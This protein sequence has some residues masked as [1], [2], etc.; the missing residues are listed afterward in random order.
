LVDTIKVV[1]R[2]N[3]SEV[4]GRMEDGALKV[5]VAAVPEDGKANEELCRVLAA[6]FG[7]ARV[8]V[9]AG[10]TGTRKMVRY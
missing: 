8:E 3:R 2:A 1:P 7:V 5:K 10:K 9:I 6:Y 4:V